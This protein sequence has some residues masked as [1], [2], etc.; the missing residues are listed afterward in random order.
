MVT[1]VVKINCEE[2]S[3]SDVAHAVAQ[4]G[5]V[6]VPRVPTDAM[7]ERGCETIPE[8]CIS[9]LPRH[10]ADVWRDMIAAA[11]RHAGDDAT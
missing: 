7:K 6:I 11:E 8:C 5:L 4:L 9:I 1:P 10:A 3:L 2:V